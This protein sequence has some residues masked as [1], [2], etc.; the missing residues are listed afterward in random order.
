MEGNA[1]SPSKSLALPT[2][3]NAPF[4]PQRLFAVA[5]PQQQGEFDGFK[6]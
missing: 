5:Y 6:K 2:R 1:F 3:P 4:D